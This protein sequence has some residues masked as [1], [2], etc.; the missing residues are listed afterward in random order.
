MSIS[1]EDILLPPLED[2]RKL[3]QDRMGKLGKNSTELSKETGIS[4][5]GIDKFLNKKT[6]DVSYNNLRSLLAVLK[7][8]Q[9]SRIRVEEFMSQVSFIHVNDKVIDAIEIMDSKGYSQLPVLD[10]SERLVGEFTVDTIR[11]IFLKYPIERIA[12]EKEPLRIGEVMDNPPP[13]FPPESP[14]S[15]IWDVLKYR[16]YVLVGKPGGRPIGII[17]RRDPLK[18]LRQMLKGQK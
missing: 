7:Y 2:L 8:P 1:I 9:L 15:E 16:Y 17:T 18:K 4:R 5:S 13:V 14:L 10:E 3:I 11:K 6:E 12:D